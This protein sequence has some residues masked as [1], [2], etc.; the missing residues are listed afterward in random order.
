[1]CENIKSITLLVLVLVTT[2]S[3]AQ[4]T[5]NF[6]GSVKDDFGEPIGGASVFLE[7]T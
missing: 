6:Y 7:G 4:V 3:S 5:V 2:Y 1:M